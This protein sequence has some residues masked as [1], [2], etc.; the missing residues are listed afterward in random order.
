MRESNKEERTSELI[1]IQSH[2]DSKR[3]CTLERGKRERRLTQAV[4]KKGRKGEK[5]QEKM[6]EDN[7]FQPTKDRETGGGKESREWRRNGKW[8]GQKKQ[9]TLNGRG[10]ENRSRKY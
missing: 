6:A 9:N 8:Y 5:K 10:E 3:R 2:L 1:L 7:S 4:G